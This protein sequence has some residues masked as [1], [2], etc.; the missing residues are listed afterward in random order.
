MLH[1]AA[2]SAQDQFLRNW[3]SSS[4]YP[5]ALEEVDCYGRTALHNAVECGRIRMVKALVRSNPKLTQLPDIAGRVPLT[6][7]ALEASMNKEIAWFLTKIQQTM[8][9][10]IPSAVPLRLTPL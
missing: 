10:V 7:S 6:M 4:P 1:I 9:Q 2:W 3:L 5:E 8:G